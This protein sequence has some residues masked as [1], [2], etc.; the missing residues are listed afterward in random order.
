MLYL[1]TNI[2]YN[3][4]TAFDISFHFNYDILFEIYILLMFSN[5]NKFVRK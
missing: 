5:K 2:I 1:R 4:V 3:S